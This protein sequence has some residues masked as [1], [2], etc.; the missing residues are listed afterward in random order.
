MVE[1]KGYDVAGQL[2]GGRGEAVVAV[3]EGSGDAGSIL[4]ELDGE[5]N[6]EIVEFYS[7]VPES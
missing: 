4:R 1:V 2:A 6:C 7:G 3:E 5:W